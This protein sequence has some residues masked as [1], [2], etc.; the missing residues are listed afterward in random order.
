MAKHGSWG[1]VFG[2]RVIATAVLDRI[3]HQT[4]IKPARIRPEV[5]RARLELHSGVCRMH[6][7]LCS[8]R[9]CLEFQPLVPR[10]LCGWPSPAHWA[11]QP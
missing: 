10:D 8:R 11:V 7:G 4:G 2:D 5:T 6:C 1:E 3:L 9:K